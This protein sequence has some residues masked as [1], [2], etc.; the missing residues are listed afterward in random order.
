MLALKVAEEEI[1]TN[2]PVS[3]VSRFIRSVRIRSTYPNSAP[4]EDMEIWVRQFHSWGSTNPKILELLRQRYDT[5]VYGLGYV[6][7]F[8]GRGT[9]DQGTLQ[10]V[11]TK[12]LVEGMGAQ[13]LSSPGTHVQNGVWTHSRNPETVPHCWR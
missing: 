3:L 10:A 5:E 2:P 1:N 11:D 13:E 8:T 4:K 9:A 12:D 6:S 7:C